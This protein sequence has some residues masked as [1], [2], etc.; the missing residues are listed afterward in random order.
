METERT[1][2][3]DGNFTLDR[4]IAIPCAARARIAMVG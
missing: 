3:S 1:A 2:Q 4:P